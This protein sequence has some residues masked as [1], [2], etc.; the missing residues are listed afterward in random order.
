MA[1]KVIFFCAHSDDEVISSGATIAKYANEGKEVYVYVFSYGE[2]SNPVV[3]DQFI[4][5]ERIIE[6]NKIGQ[7]LGV[8]EVKFLSIADGRIYEKI[9][10]K[11]F[12]NEIKEII[13]K[14]KPYRI[15]T[16]AASDPH[17]D[18]RSVHKIIVKVIDSIDRKYDIFTFDVW[19]VINV[20]RKTKPELHVDVS[21][22][23]DKKLEAL[24]LFESQKVYINTLYPS[25]LFNARLNGERNNCKYA[26]KFLKVR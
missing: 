15:F 25:V 13:N 11:K 10:D 20:F 7:F 23:F 9:S 16:H 6:A 18:H 22:T 14:H 4:I 17:R 2:A 24:K 12:L 5:N 21:K 1:D 8:K 3:Q 26:E 19:N